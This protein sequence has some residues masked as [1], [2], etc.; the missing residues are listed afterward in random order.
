MV[1]VWSKY[2]LNERNEIKFIQIKWEEEESSYKKE[3]R[4]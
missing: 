1:F 3:N 4:K 2:G